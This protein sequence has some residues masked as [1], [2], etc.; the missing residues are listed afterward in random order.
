MVAKIIWACNYTDYLS[1]REIVD[2]AKRR[3]MAPPTKDS[4]DEAIALDCVMVDIGGMKH[5][6][7]K[8]TMSNSSEAAKQIRRINRFS[9]ELDIDAAPSSL[10]DAQVEAWLR[11]KRGGVQILCGGPERRT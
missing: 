10:G 9:Y 1:G 11:I 7:D 2:F 5:I 4:V 3:N 6:T 8:T